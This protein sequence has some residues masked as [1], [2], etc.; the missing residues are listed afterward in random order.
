[1]RDLGVSFKTRRANCGLRLNGVPARHGSVNNGGADVTVSFEGNA[2]SYSRIVSIA[3]SLRLVAVLFSSSAG[4][5]RRVSSD[6]GCHHRLMIGWR[7]FRSL[8]TLF[9]LLWSTL[10]FL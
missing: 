4:H 7:V 6:L 9:C 10:F 2:T 8:P 5:I 3:S 1:M